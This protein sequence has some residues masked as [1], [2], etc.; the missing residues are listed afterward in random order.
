MLISAQ[1]LQRWTVLIWQLH[2]WLEANQSTFAV[3]KWLRQSKSRRE[4]DM[5]ALASDELTKRLPSHQLLLI[6]S[7]SE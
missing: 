6:E 7:S 1:T 4:A 3:D 2:R 5:K